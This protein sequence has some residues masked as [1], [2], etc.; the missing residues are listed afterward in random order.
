MQLLVGLRVA[1]R[2]QVA[3][4]LPAEQRVRRD[5]PRGAGEVDLALEE[6]QEQRRVVEPP[7]LAVAVAERLAEQL[8]GLA[9]RPGSAPGRAPSRR[10]SRG[11]III[12][13]TLEVVVEV[14]EHVD[15]G[16]RGVGVEERGVGGDP[17]A[18]P[19]Q[20]ADRGHGL[21][22]HAFLADRQ[23]VPLAQAVDV[24]HPGEVAARASNLSMLLGH[25]AARWCTGR[26][27]FLR[28]HQLVDDLVD[29]RVHERLAAGDGHHRGAALLASRRRACS[30]GMRCLQQR[31]AAA[32]SCRS[33][34]T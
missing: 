19:P 32:G 18:A 6:V 33:R 15:D 11:E 5:G 26:R 30:T 23:V 27:S 12:W 4:P 34:R 16:L 3:G 13:S 9:A 10:R 1:V 31:R 7:A 24:H 8:P 14:V 2:H 28:S 20:F 29:L 17:E 25:A 21:V 22:E